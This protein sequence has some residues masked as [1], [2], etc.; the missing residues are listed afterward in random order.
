MNSNVTNC[1]CQICG[2]D[3][4]SARV[5]NAKIRGL[6]YRGVLVCPSYGRKE[7]CRT[8][9]NVPFL[10][11]SN[12]QSE[13]RTTLPKQF[14]IRYISEFIYKKTNNQILVIWACHDVELKVDQFA[15]IEKLIL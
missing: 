12:V 7:G 10:R 5:N 9:Y 15:R 11:R 6:E 2:I 8:K 13:I 4:Y 14:Y 1:K 3:F